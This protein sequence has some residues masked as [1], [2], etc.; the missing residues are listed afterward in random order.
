MAQ[1]KFCTLP[2][3]AAGHVFGGGAKGTQLISESMSCVPLT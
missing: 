3:D 2:A 1:D